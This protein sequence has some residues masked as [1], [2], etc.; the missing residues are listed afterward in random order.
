MPK[1]EISLLMYSVGYK[2]LKIVEKR[3]GVPKGQNGLFP[4][5]IYYNLF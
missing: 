4:N 5:W 1:S 3:S 2:S